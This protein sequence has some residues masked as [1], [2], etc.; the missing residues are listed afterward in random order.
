VQ[1]VSSDVGFSSGP[2]GVLVILFFSERDSLVMVY[3]DLL[4]SMTTYIARN[5]IYFCSPILHGLRCNISNLINLSKLVR[6]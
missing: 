1:T 3:D 6:Y 4:F 5:I 2:V